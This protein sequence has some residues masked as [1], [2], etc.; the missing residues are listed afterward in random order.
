MLYANPPFILHEYENIPM[1]PE[2]IKPLKVNCRQELFFLAV[3][4]LV[5]FFIFSS[6][7]TLEWLYHFSRTH[8]HLELDEFIPLSLSLAFTFAV[9]SYRRWREAQVFYGEIEYLSFHDDLTGLLNRRGAQLKMAHMPDGYTESVV[10]FVDIDNFKQINQLYG[11]DVGDE[12]LKKL[13]RELSEHYR[14]GVI[15]RWAGEELLVMLPNVTRPMLPDLAATFF[16]HMNTSVQLSACSVTL[17]V[18]AAWGNAKVDHA[19][20]LTV[21]DEALQDAKRLGGA[22]YKIFDD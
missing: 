9:F 21:V 15:A 4:N 14:E 7:D 2:H 1:F 19:H 3:I 13:A 5:C 11:Y 8:E 12:V 10:F 20:I 16:Q 18:G 22:Q 17:S 6:Y